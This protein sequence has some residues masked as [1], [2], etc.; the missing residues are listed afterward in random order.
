LV[1]IVN[2]E[3]TAQA[4]ARETGIALAEIH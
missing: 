4:H 3:T 2:R 1:F